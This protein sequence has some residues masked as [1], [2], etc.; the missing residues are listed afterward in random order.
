[1][2]NLL[3]II[4]AV[5]VTFGAALIALPAGLIVGGILITLIGISLEK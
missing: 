4:G 5:A 1:M 3:Q 2:K